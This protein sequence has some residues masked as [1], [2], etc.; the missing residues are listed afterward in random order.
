MD[1]YYNYCPRQEAYFSLT[2]ADIERGMKKWQQDEMRREYIQQKG[3][4]IVEMWEC[5]W[6][7]LYNTDASVKNRLREKFP[8]RRPLS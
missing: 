6:W 5:E 8:Y 3:Y 7:S 4:Q 2:D 1:C